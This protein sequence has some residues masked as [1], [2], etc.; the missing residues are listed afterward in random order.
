MT[1]N[2]KQLSQL[3]LNK[4]GEPVALPA[5]IV[6]YILSSDTSTVLKSLIM[7]LWTYLAVNESAA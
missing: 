1:G 5:I 7:Q 3:N 4:V 6:Q 2:A